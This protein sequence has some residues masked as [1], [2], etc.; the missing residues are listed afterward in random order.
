MITGVLGLFWSSQF[1]LVGMYG[2]PFSWW[3]PT[4]ALASLC[5]IA[6][7]LT[8]GFVRGDWV[9]WFPVIG[10][11]ILSA[12]FVPAVANA[13]LSFSRGRMVGGPALA[14][15]LITVGLILSVFLQATRSKF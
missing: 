2:V 3:I 10:G 6:G 7:A 5:L 13:V 4:I 14:F 11:G 9:G 8:R 15:R 1:Y 12:Y